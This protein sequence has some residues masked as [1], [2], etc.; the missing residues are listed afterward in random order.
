MLQGSFAGGDHR[1]QGRQRILPLQPKGARELDLGDGQ[2]RRQL[3]R[4][5]RPLQRAP[6]AAVGQQPTGGRRQGPGADLQRLSA[7]LE[8]AALQVCAGRAPGASQARGLRPG[9]SQRLSRGGLHRACNG[10]ERDG[11]SHLRRLGPGCGCQEPAQQQHP[12][13]Q[14]GPNRSVRLHDPTPRSLW[15]PG[16]IGAP[17]R[18]LKARPPRIGWGSAGSGRGCRQALRCAPSEKELRGP[19]RLCQE[20]RSPGPGPPG[21]QPPRPRHPAQ[22]RQGRAQR[23]GPGWGSRQP[24]PAPGRAVIRKA[25]SKGVLSKKQASRQVSR[26]AQS[27]NRASS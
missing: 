3:H 16:R 9:R 25:A 21:P 14:P 7:R 13:G 18:T 11:R 17:A 2:I 19:S 27:V 15:D 1:P 24:G 4:G 20:T 22:R 23:L 5:P 10:G 26:L 8:G 6:G 12:G